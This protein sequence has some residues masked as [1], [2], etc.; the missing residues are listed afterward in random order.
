MRNEKPISSVLEFNDSGTKPV[1]TALKQEYVKPAE[2]PAVEINK[3]P[4]IAAKP[5]IPPKYDVVQQVEINENKPVAPEPKTENPVCEDAKEDR[6]AGAKLIGEVFST[7]IL[8]ETEKQLIFIDK[9]AAHERLRFD[10]LVKQV[11]NGERQVLLMP[12]VVHLPTEV[13]SAAA[14][15]I[16][17]FMQVGI[18]AEDFGDG[19][20]IVREMPLMLHREDVASV[21]DEVA[22]KLA[23]HR[24]DLTPEAVY[25]ILHSTACRGSVMAGEKSELQELSVLLDMLRK[26]EDVKFCPHGRPVEVCVS[27]YELEKRFGRLG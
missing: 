22:L 17:K 25:E 3:Q 2:K 21:T 19:A 23:T 26:N 1:V 13:Y 4:Q 15:N 10:R 27:K 18:L 12:V 9:H 8:L 11:E 24:Q 6:F 5:V 7:Y 14:E 16:D 20:L